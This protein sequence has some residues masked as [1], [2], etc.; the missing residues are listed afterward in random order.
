MVQ[1]KC[2]ITFN[3]INFRD[4]T[5]AEVGDYFMNGYT[6]NLT[7]YNCLCEFPTS[8]MQVELNQSLIVMKLQHS[9]MLME[10]CTTIANHQIGILSFSLDCSC[11]FTSTNITFKSTSI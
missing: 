10:S 9:F 4:T 11:D 2:Q 7:V 5:L 8:N 3:D 1:G 6:A